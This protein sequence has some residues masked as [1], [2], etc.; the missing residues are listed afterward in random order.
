MKPPPPEGAPGAP[1]APPALPQLSGK[2]TV[3][4]GAMT[5]IRG[6]VQPKLYN[7]TWEQVKL[8]AIEATFNIESLDRPWTFTFAADTLEANAP[9]GS[10]TASGTVDL[11]DDG[12]IGSKQVQA[13]I[14]LTGEN[15]RTGN[16][17]AALI[18]AA[19]TPDVREALGPVLDKIDVAVKAADGK[20]VFQRCAAG[21]MI[22]KL[23]AYPTIDVTTTP[24]T[25]VFDGGPTRPSTFSLGLSRRLAQGWGVYLNPFF[26]QAVGGQGTVDLTIEQLRAPLGPQWPRAITGQG[27]L[28][29]RGVTLD[30]KDEMTGAQPVPDN[31]A[32][33]L[34]LLTG[35]LEKDVQFQADGRFTAAAGEV[36]V[37]PMKTTVGDTTLALDGSTEL[38]TGNLKLMATVVTAPKIFGRLQNPAATSV[39][40]NAAP[41]MAI[42]ITGTIRQPQL[43][44][45]N[46]K[47]DLPDVA[48]K[49]LNADVNEQITR[50]RT[51]ETQRLMQKSQN[52]VQEI[53][54]P[55]KEPVTKPA[56][57]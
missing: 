44:V 23:Q 10:I 6:T 56:A 4:S 48:Q 45:F 53:L 18:P 7:V 27:K 24:A 37:S 19:T 49:S 36:A 50:M 14:T 9:R 34:A 57:Q 51:K 32:S 3:N 28:L 13:D 30:R 15:V 43:G 46:L 22:A 29:V 12:Q 2:I 11:G 41:T 47:G 8:E 42:P 26:R 39:E 55:L 5:L 35:D 21:G 25:L 40:K 16:L 33:Q 31:L 54:R 1:P 38:E 52:Q 17:G 20:W